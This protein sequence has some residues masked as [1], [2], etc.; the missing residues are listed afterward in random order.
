MLPCRGTYTFHGK[1][2]INNLLTDSKDSFRHN[3]AQEGKVVLTGTM[4]GEF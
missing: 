3:Q 1:Y 4:R 2:V